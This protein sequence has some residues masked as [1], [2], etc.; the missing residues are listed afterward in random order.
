MQWD[1]LNAFSLKKKKLGKKLTSIKCQIL[2]KDV[3][4]FRRSEGN[5]IK[6]IC[7]YIYC[8][9]YSRENITQIGFRGDISGIFQE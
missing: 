5:Y 1:E 3:R 9:C 6:Y 2:K 8:C 4:F 7:T